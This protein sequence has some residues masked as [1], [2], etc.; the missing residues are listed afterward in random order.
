[1]GRKYIF[2]WNLIGDL[3]LGRPNLG[4]T[5][6][7]EVYRLL[8]YCL[9]DVIEE[10]LGAEGTDRVLYKAGHLAGTHFFKQ[11]FSNINEFSV[12]IRELQFRLRAM[13][14]GV[15]RVEEADLESGT[16]VVTV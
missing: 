15:L 1:M 16:F 12:F 4:P 10:E 5:I 8:Q 9:R 11:F 6:R 3:E 2:D 7:L 13:G 14:I